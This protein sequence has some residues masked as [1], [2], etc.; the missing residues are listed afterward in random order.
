MEETMN[1][2]PSTP[3][4]PRMARLAET[5]EGSRV[6]VAEFRNTMRFVND[7]LLQTQVTPVLETAELVFEQHLVHPS[8]TIANDIANLLAAFNQL[9][10][11]SKDPDFG[12]LPGLRGL[13]SARG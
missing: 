1:V 13:R 2:V 11:P 9:S 4:D 8:P 5:I 3:N 12:S 6:A 10:L 7:G